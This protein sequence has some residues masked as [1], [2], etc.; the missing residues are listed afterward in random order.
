[1]SALLS[2]PEQVEELRIHRT[3]TTQP[4]G[5]IQRRNVYQ[6]HFPFIRQWLLRWT[7]AGTG[8]RDAIVQLLRDTRASG[9]FTWTPP[10]E[11]TPITVRFA[12]D[13]ISWEAS[14][15]NAYQITITVEEMR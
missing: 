12:S 7:V 11:S 1:M 3:L 8:E 6:S 9:T 2:K 5:M 4:A 14:S 13:T 15:V 10:K